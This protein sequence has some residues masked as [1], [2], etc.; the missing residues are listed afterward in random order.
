MILALSGASQDPSGKTCF[1]CRGRG[2]FKATCP[3]RRAQGLNR[4]RGSAQKPGGG[5]QQRSGSGNRGGAGGPREAK[6][7]GSSQPRSQP[8]RPQINSVG[9]A[10]EDLE[11]GAALAIQGETAEAQ[12]QGF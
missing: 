9:P 6:G 4:R 2:H 7:S 12:P 11:L 1:H 8:R 10:M 5:P 3:Q